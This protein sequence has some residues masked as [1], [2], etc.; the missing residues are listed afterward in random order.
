MIQMLISE[1]LLLG[2]VMAVRRARD[3]AVCQRVSAVIGGS[4]FDSLAAAKTALLSHL[5]HQPASSF[6]RLA[7]DARK[8]LELHR[9]PGRGLGLRQDDLF[10]FFYHPEARPRITA[11]LL[12]TGTGISA[13]ALFSPEIR[14]EGL[15]LLYEIRANWLSLWLTGVT[16]LAGAAF[17]GGVLHRIAWWAGEHFARFFSD[18]DDP[19]PARVRYL[20]WDLVRHHQF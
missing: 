5:F 3:Q 11:L 4:K 8:C 18:S 9:A 17:M 2:L 6:L 14:E 10:N 15:A 13:L 16:V 1:T 20:Q 19:D 12:A 7:E